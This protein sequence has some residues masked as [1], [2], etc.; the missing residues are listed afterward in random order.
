MPVPNYWT[1][2]NFSHRNA[3]VAKLWSH[4]HAYNIFWV[5]WENFAGDAIDRNYYVITFFSKYLS[6]KTGIYYFCWH[7]DASTMFIKKSFKDSK[8]VK[9]IGNYALKCSLYLHFSIKQKLLISGEKILTSAYGNDIY[10]CNLQ[11][12]LFCFN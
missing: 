9:R 8:K 6:F 3:T 7:L 1:W 11:K 5:T 10:R 2:T 4:D 12:V